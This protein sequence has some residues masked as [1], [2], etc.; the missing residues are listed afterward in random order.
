MV[1]YVELTPIHPISTETFLDNLTFKM[2]EVLTRTHTTPQTIIDSPRVLIG[3]KLDSSNYV[4]WPQ[5]VEMY[6]LGN[7]KLEYMND[8]YPPHQKLIHHFANDELRMLW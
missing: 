5:M 6:I 8:N 4:L 1:D 7:D 3:I 2:M